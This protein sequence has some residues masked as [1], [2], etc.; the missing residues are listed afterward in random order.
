V[1]EKE[2]EYGYSSGIYVKYVSAHTPILSLPAQEDI[3]AL[4]GGK[5]IRDW[6]ARFE[7]AYQKCK[8]QNVTMVGGVAPTAVQFGRYLKKAHKV[9]PRDLWPGLRIM[10]LGSVPGINTQYEP[11]L[12]AYYGNVAI[13]E[14]YGATE[15]M[16]GQQKDEKRAW[17]PN[18]D[19]FLLEVQTGQAVKSL[20]EMHPGEMG[21]LIVSTPILARYKIGDCI[22][23]FQPPYFRCVGRERWWTPLAYGWNEF[24]SLNF[25]RL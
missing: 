22:R 10:T 19:L 2:L 13:R 7:L 12:K 20:H 16:F 17:S 11:V 18:Y 24:M 1:G 15:G 9:F 4:G 14:I 3:D 23:A 5:T 8:D 21:S 25:G 6:E